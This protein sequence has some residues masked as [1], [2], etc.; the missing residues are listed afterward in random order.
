MYWLF[1]I[2][3]GNYLSIQLMK[4]TANTFEQGDSIKIDN[5]YFDE[6]LVDYK[7]CLIKSK[8]KQQT[9]KLLFKSCLKNSEI[10]VF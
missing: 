3:I 2:I 5:T 4:L 10:V 8:C 7:G 6:I 9:L 1:I